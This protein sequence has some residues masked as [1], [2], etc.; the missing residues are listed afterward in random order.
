MSVTGSRSIGRPADDQRIAAP[1]AMSP[2]GI[3]WRHASSGFDRW[4]CSGW[5]R[6]SSHGFR[7]SLSF[8]CAVRC[9]EGARKDLR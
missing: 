2:R 7:S 6:G 9:E 4:I 8:L 5:G 3:C 1:G